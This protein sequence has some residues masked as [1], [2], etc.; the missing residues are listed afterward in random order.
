MRVRDCGREI[1]RN[2]LCR[3]IQPVPVNL[4]NVH[5]LAGYRPGKG[6]GPEIV[7]FANYVDVEYFPAVF[8]VAEDES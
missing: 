6:E 7:I 4:C 3:F 8:E 1:V 5:R 2:Y